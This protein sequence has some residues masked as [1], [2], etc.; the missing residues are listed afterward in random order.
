MEGR[1]VTTAMGTISSVDY[2]H[3]INSRINRAR[4]KSMDICWMQSILKLSPVGC[5]TPSNCVPADRVPTIRT[6]TRIRRTTAA[7]LTSSSRPVSST[8][9]SSPTSSSSSITKTSTY[10]LT[11][12]STVSS[13]SAFPNLIGAVIF[14]IDYHQL[15]VRY[16]KLLSNVDSDRLFHINHDFFNFILYRALKHIL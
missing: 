9:S 4:T 14:N 1:F 7:S 10:T 16:A 11:T 8:S 5:E 13:H 15:C 12:S 6:T 2:G 3:L